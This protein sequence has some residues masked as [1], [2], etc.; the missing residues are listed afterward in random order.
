[1]VDGEVDDALMLFVVLLVQ[2]L[3]DLNLAPEMMKNKWHAF[4]WSEIPGVR[5]VRITT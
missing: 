5:D 2:N 3:Y 4:L 1:M